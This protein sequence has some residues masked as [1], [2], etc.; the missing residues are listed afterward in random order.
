MEKKYDS[1]PRHDYPITERS[2]EPLLADAITRIHFRNRFGLLVPVT[3]SGRAP[4]RLALARTARVRVEPVDVLWPE[5]SSLAVLAV[6]AGRVL[7]AAD[8][9]AAAFELAVDVEA[10]AFGL[11]LK[12]GF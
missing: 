6:D 2:T 12:V 9:D 7:P 8:A 4:D 5:V 1:S 10:L 11:D 3:S